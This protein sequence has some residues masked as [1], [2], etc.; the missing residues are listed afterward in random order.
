M[1]M[2]VTKTNTTFNDLILNL[3]PSNY[4]S[5]VKV[6]AGDSIYRNGQS[7]DFLYVICTGYYKVEYSLP[8]GQY[9]INHFALPGELL[10]SDGLADGSFHLDVIALTDGILCAL[11]FNVL[12]KLL[13]SQPSLQEIYEKSLSQVINNLQEHL[14][15]LGSHN[16]EQRLAYF[17]VYF[18]KSHQN[19]NSGLNAIRLPMCREDLKSY[20]GIT[21]ETLSRCF[22]ML[23]K[24]GCLR[25]NNRNISHLDL[26]RLENI[27]SPK[28]YP[29]SRKGNP[30]KLESGYKLVDGLT[31]PDF[32]FNHLIPLNPVTPR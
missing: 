28:E 12:H 19:F 27:I 5:R 7:L 15:S 17:L 20:L 3:L 13:N 30:V 32:I 11:E 16:A 24:N 25:I 8:D 18:Y 10:G 29:L 2:K 1:K 31:S 9:Q 22:S 26:Q 6:K 14:F 4:A 23:E 21:S